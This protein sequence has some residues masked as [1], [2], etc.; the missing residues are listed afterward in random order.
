MKRTG[1]LWVLLP[2][3]VLLAGCRGIDERTAYRLAA[4]AC[5]EQLAAEGQVEPARRRDAFVALGKNAARVDLPFRL[6]QP[7]G[8]TREG[9]WTAW[10][11]RIRLRWE[12][13]RAGEDIR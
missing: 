6:V 7:D 13:D 9:R 3:A 5:R 12:L 1:M 2:A 4:D 11:K 10:C 8:T